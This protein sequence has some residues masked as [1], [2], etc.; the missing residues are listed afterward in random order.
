MSKETGTKEKTVKNKEANSKLGGKIRDVSHRTP[1]TKRAS[2]LHRAL[3]ISERILSVEME[4][5]NLRAVMVVRFEAMD[6]RF[7]AMDKRFEA[8]DRRFEDMQK[9]MDK[10]FEDM[11]KYMDKR[12][13]I[14]HEFNKNYFERLD[15][16]INQTFVF[17]ATITTIFAGFI[18]Y[19][20]IFKR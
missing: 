20:E 10:R 1:K 14:E 15:K 4:Q 19:F 9:S 6:K 11:Q 8:I 2:F 7:E 12:F 3:D 17:I 16:K 18:A 13:E 5:K